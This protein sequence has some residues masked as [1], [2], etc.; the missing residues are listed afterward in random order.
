MSGFVIE[1]NIPIPPQTRGCVKGGSKWKPLEIGDSVFF[2]AAKG[3]KFGGVLTH[4]R[5]A[6]GYRFTQRQVEGGVRVWRIA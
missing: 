3:A 4:A 1:K 6:T 5:R 2:P